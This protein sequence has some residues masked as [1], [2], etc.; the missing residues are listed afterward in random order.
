MNQY[1]LSIHDRD[2]SKWTIF[3]ANTHE[4]VEDIDINP[5]KE[6]LFNG[7]IF[8]YDGTKTTLLIHL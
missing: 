7:D 6:H 5:A 8:T 1:K 4:M 2:Y 3:D